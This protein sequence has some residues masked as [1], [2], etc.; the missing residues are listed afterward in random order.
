M[1]SRANDRS[2]AA[3]YPVGI[4]LTLVGRLNWYTCSRISAHRIKR[5]EARRQEKKAR[6]TGS[7][8]R[9]SKA[10][11]WPRTR[12]PRRNYFLW[13]V[14]ARRCSPSKWR[15][16]RCIADA[17]MHVDAAT[18][19]SS[20]YLHRANR[21]FQSAD[22]R[23]RTPL[24]K[25]SRT[26][27]RSVILP[28]FASSLRAERFSTDLDSSFPSSAAENRREN[29]DT[30]SASKRFRTCTLA[31]RMSRLRDWEPLLFYQAG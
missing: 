8:S 19:A 30:K 18:R 3:Y 10:C 16:D 31:C 5:A 14:S 4:P 11:T 29:A 20:R 21:G 28:L 9:E 15:V 24:L 2:I 22:T 1:V 23:S 12:D 27:K 6:A 25:T 7:H 26:R 17:P 13:S